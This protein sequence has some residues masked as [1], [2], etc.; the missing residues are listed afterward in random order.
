MRLHEDSEAEL[1]GFCT[2]TPISSVMK[3]ADSKTTD[4][5]EWKARIKQSESAFMDA[6]EFLGKEKYVNLVVQG[7]GFV[8]NTRVTSPTNVY[9]EVL[10]LGEVWW[11]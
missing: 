5:A 7:S 2:A 6:M 8:E 4:K 11:G 1:R 10:R 3:S 9:C